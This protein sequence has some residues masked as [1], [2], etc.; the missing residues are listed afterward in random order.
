[1]RGKTKAA[2]GKGET[3]LLADAANPRAPIPSDLKLVR[4]ALRERWPVPQRTMQAAVKRLEEIV[5]KPVVQVMTVDGVKHLDGPAD[6]NAVRAA[7]V[8]AQMESQNQADDHLADKNERLDAGKAT[9]RVALVPNIILRGL[10]NA[11][12]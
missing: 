1:M 10:P 5:N 6:A 11:T 8:L 3:T 4:R 12:G 9:D 2:G 7:S